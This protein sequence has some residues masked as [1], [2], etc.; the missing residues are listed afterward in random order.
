M[1]RF[2]ILGNLAMTSETIREMND[3]EK[4][5][6]R[7]MLAPD[8]PGRDQLA[9]QLATAKVQVLDEDGSLGFHLD[10]DTVASNV[11]YVTPSEGE[12]ED[13]DGIT[14]HVLLFVRDGKAEELEFYR[15]DNKRVQTWPDPETLRVFAPE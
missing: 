4:A 1:V 6:I 11:K 12:Y 9:E 10:S 13:P 2:P 8:F 5:L 7:K 3:R 15:D 14:I